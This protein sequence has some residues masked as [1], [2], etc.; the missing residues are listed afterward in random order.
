VQH[1]QSLPEARYPG[2]IAFGL[3]ATSFGASR[4]RAF[5]P[6]ARA[7]AQPVW[8]TPTHWQRRFY[9]EPWPYTGPARF[10]VQKSGPGPPYPR[11][12]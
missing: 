1:L 8:P 5:R 6:R 12:K 10:A 4:R 3:L 9:S 2:L 7:M 11:L